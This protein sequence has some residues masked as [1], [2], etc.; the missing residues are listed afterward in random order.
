MIAVRALGLL[1]VFPHPAAQPA[2]HSSPKH[3]QRWPACMTSS[4]GHLLLTIVAA[5]LAADA[6]IVVL[7]A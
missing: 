4:A 7:L 3:I 5:G 6:C 1:G 2:A